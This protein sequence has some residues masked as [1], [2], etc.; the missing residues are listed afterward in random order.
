MNLPEFCIRVEIAHTDT[1]E[2]REFHVVLGGAQRGGLSVAHGYLATM[3]PEM[4]DEIEGI[5]QKTREMLEAYACT[6]NP[7]QLQL[8]IS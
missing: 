1:E 4:A 3:G 8:E 5:L 2:M 6:L 7:V